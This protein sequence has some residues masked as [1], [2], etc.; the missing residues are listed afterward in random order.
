MMKKQYSIGLSLLETRLGHSV[1]EQEESIV[2]VDRQKLNR[3]LFELS[4]LRCFSTGIVI[5]TVIFEV[6]PN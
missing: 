2:V 5:N 6:H 1:C 4:W 3:A